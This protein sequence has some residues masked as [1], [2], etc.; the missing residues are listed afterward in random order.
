M[1]H[2]VSIGGGISSTLLLPLYLHYHY[3]QDELKLV[4][5]R[6]PNEHPDVYKL[7]DA[8]Q[9]LLH[10]EIE[11]IGTGQHPFD[12]FKEVRFLGNSRLDPCS[13]ILKREAMA[14]WLKQSYAPDDIL[15]VGIASDEMDRMITIKERWSHSGIN[16][17]APL[18]YCPHITR[19]TQQALCQNIL[20]WVPEMY[21]YGFLHHNC[22][23]ACIKA[24]HKQWALLYFTYP[25]VYADWERREKEFREWIGKDVSILRNWKKDASPVYTLEQFRKDI[26]ENEVDS[27]KKLKRIGFYKLLAS[28]PGCMTCSAI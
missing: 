16:V 4:M 26:T 21:K 17:Q 5:A 23:G 24:G 27:F 13:Q 14:K 9:E 2:I 8:I 11:F 7:T 3:P 20:G 15:Y 6:L 12:V 18:M 1:K 25:E 28:N 22:H 19:K 10:V